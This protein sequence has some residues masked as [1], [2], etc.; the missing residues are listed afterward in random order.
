MIDTPAGFLQKAAFIPPNEAV[1]MSR[2]AQ[3]SNNRKGRIKISIFVFDFTSIYSKLYLFQLRS[4]RAYR[5][6]VG[7]KLRHWP[8]GTNRKRSCRLFL[9]QAPSAFRSPFPYP[10]PCLGRSIPAFP[11]IA[12]QAGFLENQ[13]RGACS[14][15]PHKTAV[16][17]Q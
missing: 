10:H 6:L 12:D 3:R 8:P 13:A 9:C 15:P 4:G 5:I 1:S 7:S 16:V 11:S 2:L 17:L 14:Q